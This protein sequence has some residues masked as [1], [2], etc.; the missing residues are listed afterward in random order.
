MHV[1]LYFET[2]MGFGDETNKALSTSPKV[3]IW[4][5]RQS[6][7]HTEKLWLIRP[8]EVASRKAHG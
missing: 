7:F 3:L 8:I 4:V 2:K 6:A 1:R 5:C